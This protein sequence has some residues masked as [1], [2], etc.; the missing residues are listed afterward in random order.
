MY[1]F[2][3][4]VLLEDA[5]GQLR[6]L[7]G[8]PI[9][10]LSELALLLE[11]IAQQVAETRWMS[12]ADLWANDLYW[13]GCVEA[14]LEIVGLK[15]EWFTASMIG[16]LVLS[17]EGE[18]GDR[19]PSLIQRVCFPDSTPS[20]DAEVGSIDQYRLRTITNLFASG[21]APSYI[22]ALD[23]ADRI[24][25]EEAEGAIDAIANKSANKSKDPLAEARELAKKMESDP[26]FMI[27]PSAE[28][29]KSRLIDI[30]ALG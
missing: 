25:Y 1:K 22:E 11:T 8:C 9:G 10:K 29:P 17:T 23:L 27:A 14:A 3:T 18:D 21:L 24:T 30:K 7:R 15:S 20:S 5:R 26:S 4:P 16:E 6:K 2:K 12:L 28:I 13:R 19:L